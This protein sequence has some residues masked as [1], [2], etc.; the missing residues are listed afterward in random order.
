MQK[1][2]QEVSLN[3]RYPLWESS[4]EAKKERKRQG[5]IGK[6]QTIGDWREREKRERAHKEL[7]PP[8]HATQ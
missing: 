5:F 6:S 2:K 3:F 7:G 1:A 4:S 8:P